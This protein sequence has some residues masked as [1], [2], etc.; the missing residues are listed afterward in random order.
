[1]IDAD[2]EIAANMAMASAAGP[3]APSSKP[4]KNPEPAPAPKAEPQA[5]TAALAAVKPSE[6]FVLPD[7]SKCFRIKED[8][9][10]VAFGQR[11]EYK[12]GSLFNPAHHRPG[13]FAE[14]K[15]QGIKFEAAED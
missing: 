11:V 2:E 3:T 12:K 4:A 15:R 14:M 5:V 7:N 6:S 10:F 8:G 1:M 13:A 9:V